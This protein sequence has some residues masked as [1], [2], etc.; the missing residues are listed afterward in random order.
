MTWPSDTKQYQQQQ[1]G[2]PCGDGDGGGGG[3][4]DLGAYDGLSCEVDG[5]AAEAEYLKKYKDKI[6]ARR[7]QFDTARSDYQKMLTAVKDQLTE[8]K[9]FFADPDNLFCQVDAADRKCLRDAWATVRKELEA[10]GGSTG[11][12]CVSEED[13]KFE[14]E[15]GENPTV[16]EIQALIVRF[17]AQVTRVEACFDTLI[18]EPGALR[19][20]VDKLLALMKQIKDDK[21]LRHGF[22]LMLWGQDQLVVVHGGF[23][24]AST[25][26]ECL[27]TALNASLDGRRT[28]A[29]L[30]NLQAVSSCKDAAR[31][32]R[33][34][35]LRE[36]VVDEIVNRCQRAAAATAAT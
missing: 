16:A 26:E 30:A 27:C 14:F 17:D 20:R 18:G 11:G 2:G 36:Q 12:C 33:C 1:Q 21:D 4:C 15:L 25:F 5:V 28:L 3:S 8:L 13:A 22:A 29:H 9:A 23:A 19:A 24:G 35:W 7:T 32:K 31:T 10:C 34:T 6:L